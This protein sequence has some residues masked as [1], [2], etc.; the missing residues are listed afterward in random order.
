MRRT[1]RSTAAAPCAVPVGLLGLQKYTRPA[2]TEALAIASRSIISVRSTCTDVTGTPILR[3]VASEVPYVGAAVTSG[4]P[5]EQNA[6]TAASRI[7]PE[8]VAMI[9]FWRPTL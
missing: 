5:G 6:R 4:F 9:T 8:P 7:G 3:A 2:P 1:K